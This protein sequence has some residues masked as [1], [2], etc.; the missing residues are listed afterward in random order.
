[1]LD[2]SLCNNTIINAINENDKVCIHLDKLFTHMQ[3]INLY[4]INPDSQNFSA[5]FN[6]V[7]PYIKDFTNMLEAIKNIES[8]LHLVQRVMDADPDITRLN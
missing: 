4:F 2:N 7:I 1:M 6:N 3:I 8:N 5:A